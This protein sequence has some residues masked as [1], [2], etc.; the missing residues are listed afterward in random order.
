VY[1]YAYDTNGSSYYFGGDVYNYASTIVASNGFSATIGTWSGIYSVNVNAGAFS[2]PSGWEIY[3]VNYSLLWSHQD[4]FQTSSLIYSNGNYIYDQG[5]PNRS[6]SGTANTGDIYTNSYNPNF[7]TAYASDGSG[8]LYQGIVHDPTATVSYRQLV[9]NSPVP[10]NN[11]TFQS[12]AWNIAGST[13]IATGSLNYI[14][15][16]D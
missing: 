13:A 7:W 16:G 12:Y 9:V 14:A 2:V 10:A 4:F 15:I 5:S 1:F 3:K 8:G 11:F 6:V